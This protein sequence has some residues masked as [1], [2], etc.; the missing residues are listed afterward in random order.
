MD[1]SQLVA[2]DWFPVA[3]GVAAGVSVAAGLARTAAGV[4]E[5]AGGVPAVAAHFSPKGG[6][7][8][9]V[10]TELTA[11]RREI[12]VMAYS[13][14]GPEIAQALL[15][16]DKRGLAV[17]VLLDRS[18]EAEGYSALRSLGGVGVE[19]L[20]DSQHAIA[21]NKVMVIDGR[22]LITGSFNF[23][24]QAENENAE[25]LIV[26]KGQPALLAQYRANFFAHRDHCHP[27]GEA[28]TAKPKV[29]W[30]ARPA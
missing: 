25:N 30:G 26:L 16:A 21:H 23:T 2:A 22:T 29:R 9:A 5:W 3:V 8:A 14:T 7:T 6:C 4:R 27:P 15:A 28:T 1:A 12:L 24:R 11:A 19:V 17:R 20:I 18:N 13:F 10:V